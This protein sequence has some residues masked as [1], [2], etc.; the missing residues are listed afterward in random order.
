MKRVLILF[1]SAACVFLSGCDVMKQLGGAYTMTQ[2]KYA[3]H[4]ISDLSFSG[5]D[6]S[7]GVSL[8]YLPRITALL[9]GSSSSVPVNFTLNLDVNNPNAS[10]ALLNGLQYILSI[11]DVT[12]TTGTL[13]QSLNIPPSGT[14]LLPLVI[15]FDLIALLK[16]ESKDAVVNIA[17]NFIG[18][19]NKASN[20]SFQ[21]KPTF[22]VGS[23]PVTSPAYIPINF[24]FGGGK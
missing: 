16:G 1:L 6:L 2:C 15:G 9:T 11:D 4:S 24:A 21:I 7:K 19:G 18:I 10:A 3:Y 22:M 13:N 5:M 12:F 23:V 14:Q 8:A 20:I 17:K